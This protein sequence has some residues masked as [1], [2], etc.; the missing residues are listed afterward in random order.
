MSDDDSIELN[1]AAAAPAPAHAGFQ[2]GA[3]VVGRSPRRMGWKE[4]KAQKRVKV[5]ARAAQAKPSDGAQVARV[6]KQAVAGNGAAT[7]AGRDA[8]RPRAPARPRGS[9]GDGSQAAGGRRREAPQRRVETPAPAPAPAPLPRI[10]SATQATTSAR[11]PARRARPAAAVASDDEGSESSAGIGEEAKAFL[12]GLVGSHFRPAAAADDID[13]DAA[14]TPK[15]AG[16]FGALGLDAAMTSSLEAMGLTDPTAI[17]TAAIPPVLE[18]RD[19]LAQAPTG[20]G[21]TLAYL[22]PLVQELKSR[23]ERIRREEGALAIVVVPTRELSLQV[24]QVAS[25]LLKRFHWIVPGVVMGGEKR[26]REKARLRK[27][28][29]ILVATPGRLLDHL[30]NTEAFTVS[31]LRYLV[32]DEA[33]RLLDMGFEEQIAKAVAALDR[34][35]EGGDRSRARQTLM[36]SATMHSGVAKLARLSLR[37]PLRVGFQASENG[38]GDAGAGAGAGAGGAL[39]A[40]GDASLERKEASFEMPKA[41]RQ[42]FLL[43]PTKLRLVTLYLLL[44]DAFAKPSVGKSTKAVVFV[45]CCDSVDFHHALIGQLAASDPLASQNLAGAK[46]LKLHGNMTQ[47]DRT[48]LYFSFC[49]AKKAVLVCTDVAARGL[50]FPGVSHIV[51]YD[52]PGEAEE[53]IHRVG[54]TARLGQGAEGA[55]QAFLFLHPDQMAFTDVLRDRGVEMRDKYVGELLSESSSRSNLLLLR[56]PGVLLRDPI[57][58]S[59]Q[60]TA[61]ALVAKDGALRQMAQDAFRSFMRAYARYP[62]AVR[63][64][65]NVKALHVGH[66]ADSFGL[67]EKPS[68]IGKSTTQML[69]K[70]R[71]IDESKKWERK[72]MQKKR[73]KPVFMSE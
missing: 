51:Q 9:D 14:A 23:P 4:R 5:A 16:G 48:A 15:P 2:G 1:F 10:Y 17:Q 68:M 26:T 25:R 35:A 71:K 40:G 47:R 45:S 65:F 72:Q 46:L 24:F 61:F 37:N 12:D 42:F 63:A 52:P 27:G 22:A 60:A 73:I 49:D 38:E 41:L 29:N 13:P 3:S 36:L 58:R 32:L 56:K 39:G 20:T 44:R 53:Y 21:K 64:I 67:K 18:G 33:D 11:L 8:A 6:P 19:V 66:V 30:E 57:Y 59:L 54:R 62:A 70:K 50:D 55:G 69:A 7:S 28:I 34:K 31:E 43:V